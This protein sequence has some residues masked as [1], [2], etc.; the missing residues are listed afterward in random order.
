[1][2]TNYFLNKI[3]PFNKNL[4]LKHQNYFLNGDNR[5]NSFFLDNSYFTRI[6]TLNGDGG[7]IYLSFK[8]KD[9]KLNNCIFYYCS[10][11]NNGGVIYIYQGKNIELFKICVSYC[12]AFWYQFAHVYTNFNNFYYLLSINNCNNNTNGYNI[13]KFMGGDIVI[14]NY[15]SSKNKNFCDSGLSI[16]HPIKLK[17]YFC[18]IID[19]YVSDDTIICLE[20]NEFNYL[21]HYNIINNNSPQNGIVLIYSGKYII[22]NS[23]FL[24]NKD[25]LLF[26]KPECKF[27]I[28][29][30]QI[31]H[32]DII[33]KGNIITKN[34][35]LNNKLNTFLMIHYSTK[36][37]LALYLNK[38]FTKI[39][40]YNK[41]FNY[42]IIL[43]LLIIFNFRFKFET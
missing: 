28:H 5:I 1:M 3:S 30:C 27:E 14:S 8:S 40:Y 34:I 7:I 43:F 25:I 6:N 42:L 19:N 33:Y 9:L 39:G 16:W 37:C 36:H 4:N 15:N 18:S 12:F 17:S 10:S 38:E 29:N 32:F 23:I 20:G 21:S 26:S 22:N 35:Q 24:N 41:N 13:C 31:I 2:K 11:N